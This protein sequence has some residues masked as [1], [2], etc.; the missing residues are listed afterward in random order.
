ME[1]HGEILCHNTEECITP[2]HTT[3][4]A[5]EIVPRRTRCNLCNKKSLILIDCRHCHHSF[6]LADRLP[7][8]H[9]CNIRVESIV[10]ERV[11]PSKLEKI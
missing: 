5:N 3:P 7:E 11:I 2:C 10:M 4:C 9:G 6:C 1:I 8:I